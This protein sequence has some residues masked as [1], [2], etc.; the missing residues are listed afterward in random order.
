MK[1]SP[2]FSRA[3]SHLIKNSSTIVEK[4]L[5]LDKKVVYLEELKP[6]FR[7]LAPGLAKKRRFTT[8]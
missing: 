3:K 7:N 6:C 8:K 4:K 1:L 2:E 5:N